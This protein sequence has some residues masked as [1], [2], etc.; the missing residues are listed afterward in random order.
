MRNIDEINANAQPGWRPGA[1]NSLFDIFDPSLA[2]ATG[3]NPPTTLVGAADPVAAPVNNPPVVNSISNQTVN[4]NQLLTVTPVAS[5]PDGNALTFSGGNLPTGAAVNATTGVLTWT[6]T[7]AQAG[8]YPNVTIT[9]T[10]NG[11]PALSASRQFTI[12]VGDVNRPPVLNAIGAKTVN[13]GQP[14]T[15][16]ASATD[17]DGNALT[18]SATGL[19]TGAT[20]NATTGAF[21]WTPTFAQAGNATV[22]VTVTDNG[23]PAAN[24]SETITITVGNVNQPP[25]L[26]PIGSKTVGENQLLTFTASATDPDGNSLT[27]SGGNLP[28]GATLTPQ[29]VF[30]WTPSFAQAGNYP[31]V[32]ITVTDNGSPAA[33]DSET[34][35]LTVNDVPRPPVLAPIGNKTATVGQAL[36]FTATASDPDGGTL[37]FSGSLPTGATLN[38]TTGAFSWTPTAAGNSSATVTV[39]DAGGL[40]DSESITITVGAAANQPPVLNPIGSKTVDEG[41]L[42]TFTATASDPDGGTLTFSATGLPAGA[43]LTP[44]GVFTWTPTFAQAGNFNATIIVTDAGGLTDSEQITLTVGNV[45]RPPVLNLIGN[46]SATVGA[47]LTFTASAAD[48]DGDTMTFSATGLPAGATLTP[49]GVFSWTPTAAGN[50]TVTITVTDSGGATD[51]ETITITV[52]NVNRPP[53]LNPIGSKTVGENQLLTFTAT[54]SDPDGDTL[55]FSATGL[56]A[57][58]TLTPQGVFSWTPTFAQAGSYT[59]TITV[60]D[61]GA[62]KA[63]ESITITVGNTNRAPSVNAITNK[64]ATEGQALAFTV[65]GTDPDGDALTFSATGLPAGATLS[66]TGAFSWTPATGQASATPYSVT[67][68]ATD[69]GTPALTSTAVT[70]TITVSAP[71]VAPPPS[72][73][74]QI[75]RARRDEEKLIV[76]GTATPPGVLVTIVNANTG[77]AL[78]T[79]RANSEGVFRAEMELRNIPCFVQAKTSAGAVSAVMPVS[80]GCGIR[81]DD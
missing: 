36:T 24:D 4:E 14:L 76:R 45:N 31:N 62:L 74:V 22:T 53:V 35:T 61:P 48:P 30:T 49:Q 58:A 20:L 33:S 59:V 9:A 32:V 70:F 64:T 1:N 75:T 12:T 77:L 25:V 54:A 73:T 27:F 71:V 68:T 42:L 57:G 11:S 29:G 44:A 10:D 52:G 37:T 28:T 63:Q 50:S 72:G 5:D 39:T 3:Q 38:P 40:T 55:T 2:T 8:N 16:T 17:P 7:F 46:K 19:P 41:T 78:R 79:V 66:P 67:V 15:F 6:P 65:S 23:T 34:I 60:S 51:S 18:F 80:G 13:E 81:T 56:P 21:A 26:N 43:T 47:P 69:N